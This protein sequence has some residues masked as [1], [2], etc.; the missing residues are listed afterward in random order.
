MFTWKTYCLSGLLHAVTMNFENWIQQT[1]SD[2]KGKRFATVHGYEIEL[3]SFRPWV[4]PNCE[5]R[6]PDVEAASQDHHS[7]VVHCK[8]KI[9]RLNMKQNSL[10]MSLTFEP[11]SK[12]TNSC[13]FSLRV[14]RYGNFKPSYF[15]KLWGIDDML[16][17]FLCLE[18]LRTDQNASKWVCR[19]WV[20]HLH[21]QCAPNQKSCGP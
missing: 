2:H 9:T 5:I 12:F 18:T 17:G 11:I 13:N 7:D 15:G 6:I 19:N 3:Y 14:A 8:L 21:L 10:N 16:Q 20:C 1:N 4:L